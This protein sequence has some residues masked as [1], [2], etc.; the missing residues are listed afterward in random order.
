M[1]N[2]NQR[3]AHFFLAGWNGAKRDVDA[4]EL[5]HNVSKTAPEVGQCLHQIQ[6]PSA[7]EQAAWH[8]G[9]DEGRAQAEGSVSN[10][11]FQ[12]APAAI[13]MELPEPVDFR[14]FLDST[15]G[16]P[17]NQQEIQ[18]TGNRQNPF[19]I[20]GID[21]DESFPNITEALYTEQQVRALLAQ[22]HGR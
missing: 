10:A 3:D 1:E 15:E 7:A 21:H 2:T 11:T 12:A 19:G 17:G 18:L 14:H 6:E 8:A 9:L 13:E 22:K 5:F 4:N 16:I 20:P